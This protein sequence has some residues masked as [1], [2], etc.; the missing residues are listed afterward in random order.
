MKQAI[1]E[2]NKQQS[3]VLL[4][5]RVS[6]SGLWLLLLSVAIFLL[7]VDAIHC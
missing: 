4:G 7:L 5:P 3:E 1:N 2:W 6:Y